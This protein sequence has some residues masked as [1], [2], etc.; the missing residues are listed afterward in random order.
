MIHFLAILVG[1]SLG[2]LGSGG[3]IL[4]VPILKYA[5]GLTAKEAVA[6]SLATVGA[7]SFVGG[8]LAWREGRVAWKE[9]ALF[10]FVATGGTFLGVKAAAGL[11]DKVQM[12]IF[13]VVMAYA[14]FRMV[15]KKSSTCG[16][17]EDEQQGGGLS[18]FTKALGVGV[19]TGVVGVGGGFLIVPA[20]VALFGLPMKRA[21]GT[22]LVVIFANCLVGTLTYSGSIEMDWMF[23]AFFSGAAVLGLVVG[24]KWAKSLPDTRLRTAFAA[25]VGVVCLYT[26]A[27]EFFP[28]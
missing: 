24:M 21:T 13:V 23:T 1:L 4:A 3:S 18:A 7:V 14:V 12:G 2:M 28:M 27:R 6:T 19:L 8:L 26:V 16:D 15:S 25:L 10:S 20:L 11:S 22:S 9:A 17:D 5:G